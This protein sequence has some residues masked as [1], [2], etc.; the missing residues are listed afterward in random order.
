MAEEGV[1][2][3][4]CRENKRNGLKKHFPEQVLLFGGIPSGDLIR[5]PVLAN[6]RRA[7][8]QVRDA[9]PRDGSEKMQ[10]FQNT[11]TSGIY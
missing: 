2:H 4:P 11:K 8:G 10:S 6:Q 9:L 1:G 7:N 5:I 3:R